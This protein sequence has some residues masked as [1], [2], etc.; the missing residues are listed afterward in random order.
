MIGLGVPAGAS[1]P[2]QGVAP[3][4]GRVSLMAGTFG[5]ARTRFSLAT[6]STRILP[7]CMKGSAD[8]MLWN[9]I[10][11]RPA[12]TSVTEAAPPLNGTCWIS[13]P[14]AVF[15]ISPSRWFNVPFPAEA[16]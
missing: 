3:N 11:M 13:S 16:Y 7:A 4:P 5:S 1:N 14:A 15:S 10:G 12:T 2:Y 9:E 6:A 8:G